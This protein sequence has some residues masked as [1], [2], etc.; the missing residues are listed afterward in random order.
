MSSNLPEQFNATKNLLDKILAL[1]YEERKTWPPP[2]M[3]APY[4]S[5]LSAELGALRAAI[6]IISAD[7]DYP[8]DPPRADRESPGQ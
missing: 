3:N 5:P 4:Y 2:V 8:S 7:A 1:L 6:E